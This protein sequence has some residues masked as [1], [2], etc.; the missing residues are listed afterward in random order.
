MGAAGAAAVLA[1]STGAGLIGTVGGAAGVSVAST[2]IGLSVS[3]GGRAGVSV[4]STGPGLSVSVGSGVVV[5]GT[6]T[7]AGVVIAIVGVGSK[8]S[9]V[10]GQPFGDKK[11]RIPAKAAM[12][13][14]AHERDL[15]TFASGYLECNRTST[16][17][18]A[19]SAMT[20]LICIYLSPP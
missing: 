19:K 5:P 6:S 17:N 4:T 7:V 2:G 18:T 13:P 11:T 20:I 3:V 15:N 14:A 10:P 9:A 16:T 1:T 8:T 12:M